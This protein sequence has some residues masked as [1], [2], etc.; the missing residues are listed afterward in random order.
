[1]AETAEAERSSDLVMSLLMM[2]DGAREIQA[3]ILKYRDGRK[4]EWVLEADFDR[5]LL[6]DRGDVD[7]DFGGSLLEG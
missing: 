2:E 4:I 6:Q 3:Q 5:A 7:S 1:L